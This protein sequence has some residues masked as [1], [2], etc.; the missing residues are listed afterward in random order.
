MNTKAAELF[1]KA[2]SSGNAKIKLIGDSITHGVGGTGF[3][4]NGDVILGD[5]RR[6]PNSYC[7]ANLFRDFAR[8]R[9]GATVMNNAI[10]GARTGFL[11]G[12]FSALVDDSDDLVICAIGTNDRRQPKTDGER[13]SKDEQMQILYDGI[14]ALYSKCKAADKD[15]IF[16]ANI[17]AANR[18]E[19]DGEEYY[20]ILT[21]RDVQ[22]VY[23]RAALDCD[24]ALIRLY[25]RF[26]EYCK[27]KSISVDSLLDDG[28]HPNDKGYD[29][30]YKLILDEL[31]V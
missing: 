11:V 10:L 18:E 26:S 14:V 15:I 20:G 1:S 28:L 22:D 30:M 7:W 27:E 21:M 31:G 29:V 9:F 24:F 16:I 23:D 17:P 5:F 3:D 25:S 8:E 6:S 13:R 4:M 12:N 2:V 19:G